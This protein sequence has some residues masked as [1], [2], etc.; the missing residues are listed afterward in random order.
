MSQIYHQYKTKISLRNLKFNDF[1]ATFCVT[2]IK[3]DPVDLFKPLIS[4]I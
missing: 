1:S 4:I 3:K 2:L